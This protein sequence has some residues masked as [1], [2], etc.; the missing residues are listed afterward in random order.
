MSKTT[1][2]RWWRDDA[3]RYQSRP[4]FVEQPTLTAMQAKYLDDVAAAHSQH[5]SWLKAWASGEPVGPRPVMYIEPVEF[6][7]IEPV[8]WSAEQEAELQRRLDEAHERGWRSDQWKPFL[9]IGALVR[10]PP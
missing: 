9:T 1:P 2:V 4:P 8:S 5:Q 10:S 7:R 6:K 3:T